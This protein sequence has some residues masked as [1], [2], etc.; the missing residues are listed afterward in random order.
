MRKLLITG[1]AAFSLFTGLAVVRA[2]EDAKE[3]KGVLIDQMC[4]GKQMSKDDPE[5]AAAGHPKA[6]AMKESCAKSGYAVISGKKM[7]KLDDASAAKA[8][9]YL[10]K[11][12]STKVVVKAT[13]KDDT[14]T[15]E[16]IEAQKADK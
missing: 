4:G 10:E 13:E 2:A 11:N 14:L 9:E 7:Y 15:V 1:I 6:C 16:S 5:A 12:D 8:K 3:I